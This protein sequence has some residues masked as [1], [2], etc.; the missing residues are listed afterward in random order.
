MGKRRRNERNAGTTR[1]ACVCWSITSDTQTAYGSCEPRHG[2]ARRRGAY[3]ARRASLPRRRR[4][5]LLDGMT[6][7]RDIMSKDLVA[8]EPTATVAE[9]AT[10]MGGHHVGSALVIEDGRATGSSPS[11]TSS[12]RSRATSTPPIT[13]SP[14]G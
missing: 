3:H 6:T 12:G 9:A 1:L 5:G 11:G 14:T 4:L 2:Y 13:R 8:V 7:V 10:L